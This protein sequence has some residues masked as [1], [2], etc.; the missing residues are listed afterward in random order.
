MDIL[1]R[2]I[3]KKKCN[4]AG[5]AL[6]LIFLLLFFFSE[7][8][9]FAKLAIPLLVLN[10]IMPIIFK[11]FAYLWFGLSNILGSIVSKVILT[12]VYIVILM[13]VGLL[14]RISGKDPM[15]LK[16]FKKG[17]SSVLIE[18]NHLYTLADLEKPF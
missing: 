2:N 18:R 14:R 3:N 4:D 7:N 9:I 8:S 13:P 10:M 15:Q 11:P 17:K 5:Q 6:V 16:K 1:P 12:I